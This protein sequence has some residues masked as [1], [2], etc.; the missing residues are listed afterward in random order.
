ME[1]VRGTSERITAALA[2]S[3][4]FGPADHSFVA[5]PIL[6]GRADI[7][8]LVLANRHF[9]C[10]LD[11]S[12]RPDNKPPAQAQKTPARRVLLAEDDP[13]AQRVV[14]TLLERQGYVTVL[15]QNGREALARYHAEL[16]DLVLTD[17]QMPEMDGLALTAA[18]RSLEA[19]TAAQ[20]PIIG[21][22]A[23][24]KT[25]DREKYLAAG[26]DGFLSKPILPNVLF[27]EIER[28]LP[29]SG[30]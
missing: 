5:L 2:L 15:A 20:M 29:S 19:A 27:A 14:R 13:V 11:M 7:A 18:L 21:F 22:T 9:L 28:L 1:L 23:E 25:D 8:L 12:L 6:G 3:S 4:A 10:S 26:M 30:R 17:V 24:A 16:F